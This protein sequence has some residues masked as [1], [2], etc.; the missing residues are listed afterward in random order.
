MAQYLFVCGNQ[1][2]IKKHCTMSVSFTTLK[3]KS[4]NLLLITI[5]FYLVNITFFEIDIKKRWISLTEYILSPNKSKLQIKFCSIIRFKVRRFISIIF[6]NAF[7]WISSLLLSRT[8]NFFLYWFKF[9]I[10]VGV[11]SVISVSLRERYFSS[12]YCLWSWIFLML[13][14]L[15]VKLFT[16]LVLS[17][18]I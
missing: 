2:Y 13:V 14:E 15:M 17:V 11:F 3:H 6:V 12:N 7:S 5:V 18:M 16:V 4:N 10:I 9:W 8:S 1:L